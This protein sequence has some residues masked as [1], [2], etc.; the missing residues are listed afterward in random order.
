MACLG[1]AGGGG[2]DRG[3]DQGDDGD[4]GRKRYWGH[5][6]KLCKYEREQI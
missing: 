1:N 5:Y 6:M 3:D 4:W 2:W